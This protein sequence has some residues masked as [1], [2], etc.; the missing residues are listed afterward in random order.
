MQI[1]RRDIDGTVAIVEMVPG[2]ES[3]TVMVSLRGRLLIPQTGMS[4]VKQEFA[5][6]F[7]SFINE[8]LG[9]TLLCEFVDS[10]VCVM[11]SV[12][13]ADWGVGASL[14]GRKYRQSATVVEVPYQV[15]ATAGA[16]QVIE[17]VT[18]QQDKACE[19]RVAHRRRTAA[20]RSAVAELEAY[21][22]R[23]S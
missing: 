18:G 1:W 9:E 3:K 12:L 10:G 19:V 15:S 16:W 14:D 11:G 17:Y 8:M 20:V 23:L 7:G 21:R 6:V 22:D 13:S 2:T 5:D 4:G